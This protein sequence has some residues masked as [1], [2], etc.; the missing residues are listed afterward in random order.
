MESVNFQGPR[1]KRR[2]S[3]LGAYD[4]VKQGEGHMPQMKF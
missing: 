3:S 4:Q 1:F 2:L